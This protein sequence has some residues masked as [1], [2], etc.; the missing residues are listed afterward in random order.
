VYISG[1]LI[2]GPTIVSYTWKSKGKG[3]LATCRGCQRGS[4]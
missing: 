4:G 1:I 2:F 3:L